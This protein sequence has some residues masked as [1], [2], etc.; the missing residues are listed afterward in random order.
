[1]CKAVP[2]L[3]S[4]YSSLMKSRRANEYVHIGLVVCHEECHLYMQDGILP[5][6]KSIEADLEKVRDRQAQNKDP[7]RVRSYALLFANYGGVMANPTNPLYCLVY[8]TVYN[9]DTED[10][11]HFN[12]AASPLGMC[13]HVCMYHTLL[14]H[15]DNDPN[16]WRM[17]E[18]SHLIV[19][20]GVQ[21]RTLF[22]EIVTPHNNRGLL[23]DRNTGEPYPMA[24]VGDF[25]LMDLLFPGSPGDSLLLKEDDLKRLKRKGFHVSIY[26]EEKPQPTVPKEDKHKS[27]YTKENTSSSSHKEE[28]S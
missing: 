23:I 1:M 19:P 9:N 13:T 7:G 25:Y 8:P 14:Q 6:V 27:P 4:L 21:Y 20:H 17:Y 16:H 22:P 28:E 12:T 3:Y 24:D 5:F 11:N 18:G 26:R 2:L 15:V 10:Q